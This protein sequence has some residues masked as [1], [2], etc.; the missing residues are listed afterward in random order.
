MQ[1]DGVDKVWR[2]LS[3]AG[4][5]VARCTVERLMKRQGWRGVARGKVVRA[6]I[7]DS[8]AP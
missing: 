3:R 8:K 7:S 1:V 5:A 2:Q 4:V 6:T